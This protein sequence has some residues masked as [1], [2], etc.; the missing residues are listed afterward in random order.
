M[1]ERTGSRLVLEAL[2]DAGVDIIFGYPGGQIMPFF[3]EMMD[4]PV[5]HVLSRHEQMAVHTADGYARSSGKLGVVVCTSG[6]G[7]TN[8]VTGLCTAMMD[9]APLLCISGQVP[10]SFIG[11]DAFQEAD[12]MA[13]ATSVTKHAFLVRTMEELPEVIAE[14]IFVAQNGRPGPVLIDLPR[15]IQLGTTSAE[16]PVLTSLPGYDH[17]PPVPADQ[18][19]R[20]NELL[21]AAS[22]PV[23]IIGGGCRSSEGAAAE[24]RKWCELTRVPVANT[25]QG[26]G[27]ADP[28]YAGL[29]GM[30][31]VHG[32][33]RANEAV[34]KCDLLIAMGMRMDDRVT[35]KVDRFAPGAKVVH[36]DID[37]AELGKLVEVDVPI[38]AD[39]A[40]ALTEWNNLLAAE[41]AGPF[42]AWMTEAAGVRDGLPTGDM[43]ED[44][45]IRPT[46]LLDAVFE[47]VGHTP[48]V[49][50]DVGQ[51]Q[52]WTVQR[53][54][55][56]DPRKF[57]SSG[58]AGTM[59]Y[60]LPSAIGAALANPGQRVLAVVGD[61]G[62]QMALA[63]M[64]TLHTLGVPVKVLVLDNHCLG[65]VRQWQQ[66]YFNRRYSGTDMSDNPDFAALARVIGLKGFTLTDAGAV[67][68]TLRAWWDHAGPAILH[69]I[70][71]GEENVFPMVS[72]GVG[73]DQ[74]MESEHEAPDV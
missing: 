49:S 29:L 31:G 57:M 60:G 61:G 74:M 56:D 68:A 54:R 21:A 8:L 53:L 30:L 22:K 1:A 9:S 44:G 48:Y 36:I 42:D 17:N 11:T 15:N 72:P 20:A 66:L 58:G 64:I 43:A 69:C 73:L 45:M 5:R 37:A 4:F 18:I 35:G 70:C 3:D 13:L 50:T 55:L 71:S 65:M 41:P 14:A 32:L 34:C 6:P 38:H 33:W 47:M 51:N 7:A 10:V 2:K 23:C 46:R 12:V 19:A 63:E 26:I 59:G 67:D 28:A 27:A 24:F 16:V 39:L 62:F 25:L 52:M 40:A